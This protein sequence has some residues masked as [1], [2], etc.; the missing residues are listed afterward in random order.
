MPVGGEQEVTVC[1]V[2]A[3]VW[4]GSE[5]FTLC[6]GRITRMMSYAIHSV[7]AKGDVQAPRTSGHHL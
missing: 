4:H 6:L 5:A 2:C 1:L 3:V 7:C